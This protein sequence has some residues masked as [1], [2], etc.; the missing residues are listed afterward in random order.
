MRIRVYYNKEQHRGHGGRLHLTITT[1]TG[2][3]AAQNAYDTDILMTK[4]KK[5]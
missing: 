1:L 4:T 3:E 5:I 2:Q